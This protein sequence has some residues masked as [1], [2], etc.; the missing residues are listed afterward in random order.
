[1]TINRGGEGTRYLIPSSRSQTR[2]CVLIIVDDTGFPAVTSTWSATY[3]K[4]DNQHLQ[5]CIHGSSGR[6]ER[7]TMDVV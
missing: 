3:N 6:Q 2:A 5:S 1:M 7:V 4:S